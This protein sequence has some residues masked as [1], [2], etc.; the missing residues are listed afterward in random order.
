M[1][2]INAPTMPNTAS[3][4]HAVEVKTTPTVGAGREVMDTA[5]ANATSAAQ[6]FEQR[7]SQ[8][9]GSH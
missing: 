8:E 4:A 2:V 9:T 7:C 6:T 5:G 3:A 1:P